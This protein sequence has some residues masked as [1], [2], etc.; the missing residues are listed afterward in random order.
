[1]KF[2]FMTW[3]VAVGLMLGATSVWAAATCTTNPPSFSPSIAYVPTATAVNA[4]QLSFTVICT[5]DN[6]GSGGNQ[7]VS[8]AVAATNGTQPS[9][10]QNRALVNSHYLNYDL[11][12]DAACTILWPGVSTTTVSL[13]KNAS[14]TSVSYSLYVCVPALQ[15]DTIPTVSYLD[16]PSLSITGTAPNAG[17]FTASNTSVNI[18]ITAAPLCS[19]AF[20]SGSTVALGAYTAF[21]AAKSASIIFN[22]RCTNTHPYTMALDNNGNGVL[23]GLNYSLGLATTSGSTGTASLTSAGLG[24]NQT[25]YINGNMAAGQAGSC[26]G[27]CGVLKTDST[28]TLTITY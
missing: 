4:T 3:L 22:P 18:N 16:V 5:R 6:A 15:T 8:Y 20:A 25:F 12:S 17:G 23:A 19:M 2:K 21:G 10:T 24:V 13:S 1:M 26:A 7:S 14:S 27:G 28:R 11:Y 9:G